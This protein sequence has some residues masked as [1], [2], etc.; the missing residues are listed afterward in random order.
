[1]FLVGSLLL[2]ILRLSTALLHLQQFLLLHL[3]DDFADLSA[4]QPPPQRADA[5]KRAPL[6]ENCLRRLLLRRWRLLRR[7][8]CRWRGRRGLLRRCR[9]QRLLLQGSLEDGEDLIVGLSR[10]V[11]EVAQL[12]GLAFRRNDLEVSVLAIAAHGGPPSLLAVSACDRRRGGHLDRELSTG[13]RLGLHGHRDVGQFALL[14][15]GRRL[16]LLRRLISVLMRAQGDICAM[17]LQQHDRGFQ[18]RVRGTVHRGASVLILRINHLRSHVVRKPQDRVIQTGVRGEVQRGLAL[19]I[20]DVDVGPGF[21]QLGAGASVRREEERGLP[22]PVPCIHVGPG[23]EQVLH[24]GL[25]AIEGRHVQRAH[26]L[27]V[28]HVGVRL[29]V[30][31]QTHQLSMLSLHGGREWCNHPRERVNV[32]QL[33][34]ICSALDIRELAG[35]VE[36]ILHETHNIGIRHCG[37]CSQSDARCRKRRPPGLLWKTATRALTPRTPCRRGA[38]PSSVCPAGHLRS[39]PGTRMA[40][41]LK[42]AGRPG[43]AHHSCRFSLSLLEPKA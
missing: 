34:A 30:K 20:Q 28:V 7:R 32:E 33:P 18:I 39:P 21:P 5:P 41:R 11:V 3:V 23:I 37:P 25:H 8:L 10:L 24:N 36:H 31:K 26:A 29:V 9:P 43:K 2:V 15:S 14:R 16:R 19:I 27:R 35:A 22:V 17:L 40:A 4:L 13:R 1:L 6:L 12:R 42:R 38:R